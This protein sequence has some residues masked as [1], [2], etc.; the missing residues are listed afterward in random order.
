MK[1]TTEFFTQGNHTKLDR[2]TGTDIY[3]TSDSNRQYNYIVTS[4]FKHNDYDSEVH[5]FGVRVDKDGNE[6]YNGNEIYICLVSQLDTFDYWGH[7]CTDPVK[8]EGA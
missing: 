7:F 3:H 1:V 8:H 2:Y 6:L 4:D 5:L